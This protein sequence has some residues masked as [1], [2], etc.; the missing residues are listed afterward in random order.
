MKD[1]IDYNDE[2]TKYWLFLK[3]IGIDTGMTLE[4][5]KKSGFCEGLE[6]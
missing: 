2:A 4:E 1:K 3:K 5:F 6:D